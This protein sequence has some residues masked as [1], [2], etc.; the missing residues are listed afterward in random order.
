MLIKAY[1]QSKFEKELKQ[2]QKYCDECNYPN[3]EIIK[4]D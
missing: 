3:S 1:N 4:K 2:L